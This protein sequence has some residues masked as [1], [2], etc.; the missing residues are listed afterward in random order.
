[1]LALWVAL[2]IEGCILPQDEVVLPQLPPTK[3]SPPRIVKAIEPEDQVA[4][5]RAGFGQPGCE[6]L[7]VPF[8]VAVADSD[9]SDKISHVWY[10]DRDKKFEA[11]T[12]TSVDTRQEIRTV[13]SP[14]LLTTRLRERADRQRHLVEVH[15]TDGLFDEGVGKVSPGN[16]MDAAYLATYFWYV[17]VDPCP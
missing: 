17:Q 8:S 9:L 7:P 1:L 4:T 10:V 15:V 11:L 16:G 5:V 14:G 12:G 13:T 2:L 6:D 3:D